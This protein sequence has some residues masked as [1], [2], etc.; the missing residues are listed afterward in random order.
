MARSRL[1]PNLQ[2]WPP[3]CSIAVIITCCERAL[4][5]LIQYG[6]FILSS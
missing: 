6:Y 1:L 4:K 3:V 5:S 2:A